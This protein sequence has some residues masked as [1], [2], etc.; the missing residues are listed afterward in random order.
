[1]VESAP[2]NSSPSSHQHGIFRMSHRVRS[3]IAILCIISLSSCSSFGG[4]WFGGKKD[5]CADGACDG[6]ATT[7]RKVAQETW[8]CYG[9]QEDRSW[10]CTNK[11]A[12]EKIVAVDPALVTKKPK[13]R[14]RPIKKEPATATGQVSVTNDT[15]AEPTPAASTPTTSGTE[16]PDNR[17]KQNSAEQILAIPGSHYTVQLIAMQDEASVREFARKNGLNEPL[18]AHIQSQGADWYV[19]LLGTYAEKAQAEE[20]RDAWEATRILKVRPWVRQLAPLQK[21]IRLVPVH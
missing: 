2:N 17:P 15:P 3:G 18:L 8:Y 20:A 19:L 21:S 11:S 16:T 1:M 4:K 7:A 5:E 14:S 13:R 6:T 10:D 9:V 12:P